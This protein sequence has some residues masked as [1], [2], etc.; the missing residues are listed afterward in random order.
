MELNVY[1]IPRERKRG[2]RERKG[3]ECTFW[4]TNTEN[5]CTD[6][7]NTGKNSSLKSVVAHVSSA[8]LHKPQQRE[9]GE[10]ITKEKWWKKREGSGRNNEGKEVEKAR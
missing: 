8:L 1:N 7:Y 6:H 2:R 5:L 4:P 10:E 9:S 3:R